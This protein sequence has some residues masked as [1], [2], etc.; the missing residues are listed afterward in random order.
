M[1]SPIQK[2]RFR[3]RRRARAMTTMS[4]QDHFDL[5][6]AGGGTGACVPPRPSQL[7]PA[8]AFALRRETP[9]VQCARWDHAPLPLG[10]PPRVTLRTHAALQSG[11]QIVASVLMLFMPSFSAFCCAFLLLILSP[12]SPA[13]NAARSHASGD[14]AA[15]NSI[16]Q[17]SS[18]LLAT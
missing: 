18:A 1:R 4:Y 8:P 11:P 17:Y 14:Q 10:A 9:G 12:L 16:Q 2:D 15:G 3:P 5:R 7:Q 6:I 13:H